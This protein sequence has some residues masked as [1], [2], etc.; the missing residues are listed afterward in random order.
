MASEFRK[1]HFDRSSDRY[2]PLK[3]A[4]VITRNP[5]NLSWTAPQTGHDWI[6]EDVLRAVVLLES[7]VDADAW[8]RRQAA[9]ETRLFESWR[10]RREGESVPDLFD[11]KDR[12]AWLVFQA[13]AYATDRSRWS[14]EGGALI[15]PIMTRLGRSIPAL[16]KI[17]GVEDR[18]ARLM[19]QNLSHPDGGFYELLVALAYC[20][21]GWKADFIPEVRGGPKTPDL[22]VRQGRRRFR[23]E[24]KRPKASQLAIAEKARTEILATPMH[25][26]ALNAGRSIVLESVL[27]V[28]A[29]T[30]PD[31]YFA[32]RAA[33]FLSDPSQ[34][35]WADG[36][37][38]GRV[39]DIDWHLARSV[40]DRDFVYFGASR[41]IELLAGG[42]DH[43]ADHSLRAQWRP[44]P[45]RPFWADAIYQASLMTVHHKSEAS[46]L[47]RSRDI[48][49]F[50]KEADDQLGDETPGVLHVGVETWSGD[51]TD[52]VR[53][54]RNVMKAR[55]FEPRQSRL[56][57]AYINYFTPVV[58][59]RPDEAWAMHET[60][61]WN[62]IGS[63]AVLR[64]L[65]HHLAISDEN[66]MSRGEHWDGRKNET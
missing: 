6:D 52:Q 38:T 63:H 7:Y 15:A 9:V 46:I 1:G 34:D 48:G 18:L 47:G 60:T 21:H 40:L 32:Q 11:P 43:E 59:T 49:G 55:L 53:H 3:G 12:L 33:A 23:A 2:P 28:P 29:D 8:R 31:D 45:E 19:T 44:H 25:A 14:P 65:E 17:G 20:R 22:D 4:T 5:R 24:C 51:T 30:V 58:T 39:R 16:M 56:R 37:S 66:G 57:F 35:R 27:L 13:R 42:Y 26:L 54:F 61:A 64:P 62:R 36:L 50:L 10:R 41:M